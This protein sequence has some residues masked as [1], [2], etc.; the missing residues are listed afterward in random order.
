MQTADV[1]GLKSAKNV[2]WA[3]VSS[4]HSDL[5]NGVSWQLSLYATIWSTCILALVADVILSYRN[6][7]RSLTESGTYVDQSR[8]SSAFVQHVSFKALA[9]RVFPLFFFSINS[10]I[11]FKTILIPKLHRIPIL[12][13]QNGF[14]F[15]CA[16]GRPF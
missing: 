13:C 15:S 8:C 9:F 7:A 10:S 5:Y 2:K 4:S 16:R 11:H 1:T 3:L 14:C 12:K 6:W